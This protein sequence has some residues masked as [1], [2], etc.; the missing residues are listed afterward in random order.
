MNPGDIYWVQFPSSGGHEQAG[1]R[2]AIVLQD[3]EYA[4]RLP[5]VIVVPLTGAS[6]ANRFA[7][8]LAI[9]PSENNHLRKTSIALV[10]QIRAVDRGVVADRIGAI[11]AEQC[12]E[13]CDLLDKLTGRKSLDIKAKL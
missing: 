12:A 4:G 2:P 1:R 6:F 5:L 13:L 10:F 9:E 11:T 7:G 3:E 8:T